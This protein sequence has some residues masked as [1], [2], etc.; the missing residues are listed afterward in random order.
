MRSLKSGLVT[1]MTAGVL[2][3]LPMT[4]GRVTRVVSRGDAVANPKTLYAPQAKEFWLSADEFGYVRPGFNITVN[5]ITI[6]AD[7]HPVVDVSFTDDLDQPLDRA[8][9]ITPGAAV[10]QHGPRLVGCRATAIH[11]LHHPRPDEPDHP[12]VGH[13]GRRRRSEVVEHPN[14]GT[15]NDI[16]LGHAHL[17]VRD[18]ASRRLRR[19]GHDHARHLRDPQHDRHRGRFQ[20]ELLRQ[21][22]AGLPARRRRGHPG[23]GHD[24]TTRPAT[25]AT[26]RCRRT[27]ARARTSSS[28]SSATRPR[29]STRTPATPSTSR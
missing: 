15:W 2:V 13:A 20:Q 1:A 3:I 29:R 4:N 7:R 23:L 16:D 6:D 24:R 22:R 21:R 19:D 18:R 14:G 5:S 26:T 10:D 28:A 9:K 11:V 8:G 25:R 17:H 27:A 12:G